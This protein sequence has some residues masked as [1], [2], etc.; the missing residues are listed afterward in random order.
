[1]RKHLEEI[2]MSFVSYYVLG[3]RKN[4]LSWSTTTNS[5]EQAIARLA[6][7]HK[8]D[9]LAAAFYTLAGTQDVQTYTLKA[10]GGDV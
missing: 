7:W 8:E 10:E 5:E 3:V 1:M 4:G 9:G 2:E 6:K